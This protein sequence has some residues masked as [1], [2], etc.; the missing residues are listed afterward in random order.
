MMA[1]LL[2][3]VRSVCEARAALLGGA[4]IIDVKE[5]S[6]G[7]LG[8]ADDQMIA[9]IIHSV[10]GRRPVSAALGELLETQCSALS[11]QHYLQYAKFGLAGCGRIP[12]WRK[13]LEKSIGQLRR[14]LPWCQFVSVAYADWRRATSPHVEEVCAFAC[15]H[16]AGPFL[17]DTWSKD[18]STLLDWLSPAAVSRLAAQ[19]KKAGVRVALAGSLGPKQFPLLY[20]AEPDWFAVRG[21]ACRAGQRGNQISSRRVKQLADLLSGADIPVCRNR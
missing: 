21:A 3:S 13:Q 12:S 1:G 18:G 9:S 4:A 8:R 20:A 15:E 16:Q 11:T 7:S 2:V 10:S 17:L 14:A 19:C 5:P 6:R